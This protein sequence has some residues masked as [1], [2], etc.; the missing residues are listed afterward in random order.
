MALGGVGCKEVSVDGE[1][2]LVNGEVDGEDLSCFSLVMDSWTAR[3]ALRTSSLVK[4]VKTG[5]VLSVRV[6]SCFTHQP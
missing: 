5:S 1:E 6:G 3:R 4:D 2:E